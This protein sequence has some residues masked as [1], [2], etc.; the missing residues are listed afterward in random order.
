LQL[1]GPEKLATTED[2]EDE[3]QLT[4]EDAEDAEV[5]LREIRRGAAKRRSAG[6]TQFSSV[7]SVSSV[8]ESFSQRPPRPQR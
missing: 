4:T 1:A 5:T 2:T 6:E 8:V 3:N 7:S